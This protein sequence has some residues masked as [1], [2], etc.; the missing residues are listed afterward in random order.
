MCWHSHCL[1]PVTWSLHLLL[2]PPLPP[3]PSLLLPQCFCSL[4]VGAAGHNPELGIVTQR[5]GNRRDLQHTGGT[6]IYTDTQAHS[7]RV[8]SDSLSHHPLCGAHPAAVFKVSRCN[9]LQPVTTM[10]RSHPAT[11]LST[12]C[13]YQPSHSSPLCSHSFNPPLTCS[14]SSFVG[15]STT[16]FGRLPRR[17]MPG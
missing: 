6:H 7:S 14:T 2:L 12:T 5:L 10:R 1:C 16:I 11:P 15:T 4:V 13:C 9:Q 17:S 8:V 3:P